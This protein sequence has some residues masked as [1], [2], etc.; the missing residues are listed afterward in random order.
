L[1][2]SAETL[3]FWISQV[4]GDAVTEHS[5]FYTAREPLYRRGQSL[6]EFA[7]ALFRD[8]RVL[9]A[10]EQNLIEFIAWDLGRT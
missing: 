9:A 4:E 5:L 1:F 7:R 6:P 10:A 8:G 2:D 3:I